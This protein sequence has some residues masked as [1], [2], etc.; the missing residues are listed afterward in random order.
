M[1]K[2]LLTVRA[3]APCR[4]S[5][6]GGGTDISPYME[7][8]GGIV[9]S[10][11]IDRYAY[12]TVTESKDFHFETSFGEA[13]V[14]SSKRSSPISVSHFTEAPAGSGLGGSSSLMVAIMKAVTVFYG[15]TLTPH[16][17]AELA[18]KVE[19]KDLGIQGGY[20]DQFAAAYGGW[21][22]ME[23]S[24]KG[25]KV[26]RLS[27]ADDTVR[28]LL[29]SLLLVDLGITRISS[30]ILARQIAS[31]RKE[32]PKA[33]EALSKIKDI[34]RKMVVRVLAGDVKELGFLLSEEWEEK[35]R[36]D[37]RISNPVIEKFHAGML[38][39]GAIGGKLLG[40]GEGGHMIFISDISN[41][42]ELLSYIDL[43]GFRRI[44]FNFDSQ[45][46][47]SWVI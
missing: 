10:T 31:Y 8:H 17:I 45:G 4:L 16:Q 46:V 40:A 21:N 38:K 41:R 15:E 33:M 43:S 29:A 3:R 36:L 7:K 32:S 25:T 47:V 19:R 22:L 9:L 34:T 14:K 27:V 26:I 24:D 44:P 2:P 23:F 1:K 6:G 42:K 18:Y 13:V 11:T 30:K 28:E 5:F 12:C 37:E 39:H 35:K 20:Q